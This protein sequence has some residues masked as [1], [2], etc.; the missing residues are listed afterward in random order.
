MEKIKN[1]VMKWLGTNPT[2]FS[3]R[4]KVGEIL[5]EYYGTKNGFISF[6]DDPL[7]NKGLILVRQVRKETESSMKDQ[8]ALFIYTTVVKTEKIPGDVAEVGVYKGGSIKLIC[9]ATK[10][11]I[12]AFDTFEGLPDLSEH[13]NPQQF[14]RGDFS[15]SLE[16]VKKYLKDYTNI[17]FYKG[18]F[19]F[20]AE[21]VKNKMFSFVHFDVDIYE[22][23]LEC[24]KFFYPRMNKGGAIISHD[25]FGA[26]GVTKAFDEFFADKPEIIITP[27]GTGRATGQCLVI[28]V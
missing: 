7:S 22:S 6:F 2:I 23:T 9:E 19:P 20:T 11:P 17:S 8:E 13:D 18:L 27:F 3:L 1:K 25:Y 24:L 5:V 21:P 28:K 15:F 10:K 26:P 12:H 4:K 14:H 16:S